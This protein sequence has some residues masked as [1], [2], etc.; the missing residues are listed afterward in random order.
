MFGFGKKKHKTIRVEFV[1]QGESAPFLRSDVP[2]D[3]LPD[4]FEIDTTLHIKD[5]EW[6]V[7]QANPP[8]KNEF[9][10]TGHVKVE[11]AKYE[12][13]TI[14]PNQLL[15]SLPT[16]SDALPEQESAHSLENVLVCHEDDWRQVELISQVQQ[17][18]ISLEFSDII[19]IYRHQRKEFGFVQLHPRQRI[20]QPLNDHML[21]LDALKQAFNIEHVYSGVAFNRV[22]ASIVDGF[23]LR[24]ASGWTFWGQTD[25]KG[26]IVTLNL[27]RGPE[28]QVDTL[29][30][31]MDRF[32]AD[33]Q[34]L[35]VD[36]VRTFSC[37][38]EGASF[39]QFD[40]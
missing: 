37:G 19:D 32:L 5:D 34:L 31:D 6:Q 28:A 25:A 10:Q 9:R 21:T 33:H 13:T 22:A 7:V 27:L 36:W 26:H 2:I 17:D 1:R 29:C 30:V 35:L 38:Q 11:L 15:F 16:I 18:A 8:Q 24:T 12:V 39:S 23:A 14:D 20:P 40:S 4:T 3:Q